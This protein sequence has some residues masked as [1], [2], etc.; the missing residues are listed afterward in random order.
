MDD[1]PWIYVAM[2]FIAFI[3]WVRTR[4]KEAAVLKRERTVQRKAREKARNTATATP[5]PSPYRSPLYAPDP[6]PAT[7]SAATHRTTAHV[8]TETPQTFRELF[9]MLQGHAGADNNPLATVS[10]ADPA[11]ETAPPPLP[12]PVAPV[13]TTQEEIDAIFYG[14]DN[15]AKVTPAAK[16]VRTGSGGATN[17]KRMLSHR[18][19]LRE[20]LVLK[21][22]LDKPVSIRE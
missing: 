14:T 15:V 2:I 10:A 16:V 9:E 3:S 19:S 6:A 5:P 20:A 21:E 8:A 11:A 22:I 1:I 12:A 17:I 13:R 18:S 4:I 7:T